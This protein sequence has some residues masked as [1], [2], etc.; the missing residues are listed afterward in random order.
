MAKSYCQCPKSQ[1][2]GIVTQTI[3]LQ[4]HTVVSPIGKLICPF[5]K[6]FPVDPLVWFLL[7]EHKKKMLV[8]DRDDYHCQICGADSAEVHEII[9]KGSVSA[10]VALVPWNMITVC[11][12]HHIML[13]EHK[14]EILRFDPA[15]MD[16][17]FNLVH[18]F[19]S[20][21]PGGILPLSEGDLWF[22]DHNQPSLS[23]KAHDLYMQVTSWAK[24]RV[25]GDWAIAPVLA[26]LREMKG[27]KQLGE[28]SHK[29]L[30]SGIRYNDTSVCGALEKGLELSLERNAFDLAIEMSPQRAAQILK[31]VP[32]DELRDFMF[33]AAGW[34]QMDYLK[35]WNKRYAKSIDKDK[36][37]RDTFHVDGCV[38]GASQ[39][40]HERIA[41]K[42]PDDT[43]GLDKPVVVDG[44]QVIKGE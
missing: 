15:D 18:G 30:L 27:Y 10:D 38:C 22:Y 29:T 39:L 13:Q 41:L 44:G 6:Y 40:I 25:A 8:L 36:G 5:E 31:R 19:N 24:S 35:E 20:V 16:H 42:D 12:E 4:G 17:G 26:Q 11:R 7:S 21:T 32:D 3:E 34:S 1:I 9:T 33:D 14:Y 37:H 28:K 43:T 2:G 23:D